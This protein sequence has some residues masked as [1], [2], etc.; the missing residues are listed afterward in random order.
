M[1]EIKE[2]GI[3]LI[4]LIV[5]IVIVLILAGVVIA[6]LNSENGLITN[7]KR[8]KEIFEYTAAKEEIDLTLM[9]V[10]AKCEEKGVPYSIDEI[11][12]TIRNDD[13]KEI[14]KMFHEEMTASIKDGI[15]IVDP[16]DIVIKVKKYSRYKF[17][18][19]Q[20]D[21]KNGL[22]GIKGVTTKDITNEISIN[23]F[24][25]IEE[26]KTA[27]NSKETL[28]YIINYDAN[29]GK[30]I[31]AKQTENKKNTKINNNIPEKEGYIF[32]GWSKSKDDITNLYYNGSD[33]T[34][35]NNNVTLYA[36]WGK[37]L[38]Y[39][40]STG[41][42][43]IDTGV[44][45]TNN[46]IVEAKLYT[47]E[48]GNK[49]W[50]GGSGY[51]ST[52]NYAFNSMSTT[53]IDYRLGNRSWSQPAAE[54]VVSKQ[55]IVSFGKE[56][57]INDKTIAS[58]PNI[59]EFQDDKTICIFIRN[60]GFGY[61]K[62]R[63]YYLK[64]FEGENLI[65]DFIPILDNN[66][67]AGLYDNVQHKFYYNKGKG[68][69][70]YI[71]GEYEVVDYI[72]SSGNQWINTGVYATNNTIVEALLYTTE[73]GNKNWFGGSGYS[74]TSNYAFNAMSTT[75][76]EYTFGKSS[77]RKVAAENVV[78]NQFKVSFGK[79]IKINDK[80]IVESAGTTAFK[81]SA[82]ICIF[83]RNGNTGYIKGRVYYLKIFEGENLIRDFIPVID[84]NGIACLY[85]KIEKEFYYNQGKGNFQ[86][87][88]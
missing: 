15:Q 8:S 72:E 63:V 40:E 66:G 67:I 74:S 2:T 7:S 1:K 39:I 38:K 53:S 60:G 33:Y 78:S 48:T 6:Q 17:L 35:D 3:T 57:K 62:G 51:S 29:G 24:E 77:W 30:G 65:R 52:S 12:E 79:Q 88:N 75:S 50:F 76:V 61:I 13:E 68:N 5:T 18:V 14:E 32:L 23:D 86:Y 28:K 47:Q 49:N 16:T 54:N 26:Y 25:P 34:F 44:Y 71:T 46:T 42:E 21:K 27:I 19:G 36:I 82:T 87:Q 73:T 70:K 64:I 81:D 58:N 59:N 84:S 22:L 31:I 80:I 4:S 56:I 85:D 9:S 45:A 55:F 69:F 11:I 20:K 37:Q 41:T 10:V 83:V 43:Y